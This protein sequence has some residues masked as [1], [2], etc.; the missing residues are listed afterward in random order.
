MV[1]KKVKNPKNFYL[2]D[3]KKKFRK[4]SEIMDFVL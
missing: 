3:R 4:T 2:C 1:I